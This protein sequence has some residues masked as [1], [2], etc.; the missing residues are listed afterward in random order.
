MSSILIRLAVQSD[1]DDIW[2][3]IQSVIATGETYVFYPDSDRQ[4]MLAYWCDPDAFTYVATIDQKVVGTYVIRANRPD[5]GSHVANGSYMVSTDCTGKGIGK[6]MG[7]H[8]I[9]EARRLGFTAM[10]YN[11]VISTNTAAVHLWQSI[12]FTIVGEVPEA[13]YHH[14]H[15]YVSV[16]VMWRKL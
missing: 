6:I 12:G 3:I 2:K 10:Q 15:G 7:L 4:K 16:Y 13:F 11:Y 9:E 5:L 1:Y 8:S 14:A